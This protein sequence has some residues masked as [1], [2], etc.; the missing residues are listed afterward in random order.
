MTAEGASENPRKN[1]N[2]CFFYS[3]PLRALDRKGHI[4]VRGRIVS[5]FS[6]EVWAK[7][8]F[9]LRDSTLDSFPEFVIV[10]AIAVK[11]G[12]NFFFLLICQW[13]CLFIL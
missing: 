4:E 1:E 11:D 2:Q 6:P 12:I 9:K 13:W 7:R 8:I 5:L 3:L 10:V